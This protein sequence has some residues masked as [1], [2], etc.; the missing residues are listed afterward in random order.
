M[1]PSFFH[2]AVLKQCMQLQVNDREGARDSIVVLSKCLNSFRRF[3][4]AS[5]PSRVTYGS[6]L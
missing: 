3:R 5:C 2:S 6:N 1:K 4:A